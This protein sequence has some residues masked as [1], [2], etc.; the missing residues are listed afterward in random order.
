MVVC[1][2]C[3]AQPGRPCTAPTINSRRDVKYF[4][5]SREVIAADTPSVGEKVA[6]ALAAYDEIRD[7]Y[8]ALPESQQEGRAY[9]DYEDA[10]LQSAHDM[11]E[12]LRLAG[13]AMGWIS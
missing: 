6:A 2:A 4:H 1:P 5:N 7:D 3:N 12:V 8:A 10:L 11:A 9:E 13:K